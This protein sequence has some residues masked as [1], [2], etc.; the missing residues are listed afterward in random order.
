MAQVDGSSRLST[1][2]NG[3]DRLSDCAKRFAKRRDAFSASAVPPVNE[4]VAACRKVASSPSCQ[5]G[6]EP[7]LPGVCARTAHHRKP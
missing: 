1:A 7:Q 6:A 2:A 3:S 4:L 5:L